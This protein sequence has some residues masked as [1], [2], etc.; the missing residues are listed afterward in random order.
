MNLLG[1]IKDLLTGFVKHAGVK[2][3]L[4]YHRSTA[5][6]ASN[7]RTIMT[8]SSKISWHFWAGTTLFV[9]R[10]TEETYKESQTVHFAV[11]VMMAVGK[12][13]CPELDG[14]S[15]EV[16][17]SDDARRVS[18]RRGDVSRNKGGNGSS[19]NTSIDEEKVTDEE[20]ALLGRWVNE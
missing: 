8:T 9:A 10:D 17:S 12:T 16:V 4:P 20:I 19:S 3:R 1:T 13:K 14:Y 2:L 11:R 6:P 18:W 5:G 7:E 15:I